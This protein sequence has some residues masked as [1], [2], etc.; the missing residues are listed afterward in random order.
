MSIK[1]VTITTKNKI[2][3]TPSSQQ[4]H[5]L[6]A[7]PGFLEGVIVV[8]R[9]SMC[10]NVTECRSDKIDILENQ[11]SL[12]TSTLKDSNF[13]NGVYGIRGDHYSDAD[14]WLANRTNYVS[15][16]FAN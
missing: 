5:Y 6:N 1:K 13:N 2:P 10:N 16:S 11:S 12:T 3:P 8:W 4:R 9:F 14:E 15:G 7:K